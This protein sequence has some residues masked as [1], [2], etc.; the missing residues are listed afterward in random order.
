M[1]STFSPNSKE[2]DFKFSVIQRGY[3]GGLFFF[4]FNFSINVKVNFLLHL[5]CLLRKQAKF[6]H[7]I[8]SAIELK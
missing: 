5:V 6:C 2:K 3:D 4:I 7:V 1:S 8:L